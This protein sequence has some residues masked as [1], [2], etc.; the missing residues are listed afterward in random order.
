MSG[1]T[2]EA[3]GRLKEAVGVMMN[4]HRLKA[5]GRRD[6]SVGKVKKAL[7]HVMDKAKK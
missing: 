4:N 1:T 3:K 5:A 7:E 6:Q 2:D